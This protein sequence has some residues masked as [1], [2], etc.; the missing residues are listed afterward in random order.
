MKSYREF[1]EEMKDFPKR[2]GTG[3]V[4]QHFGMR[5]VYVDDTMDV[6]RYPR[7]N[8]YRD[9]N[10][11]REAL[12]LGAVTTTQFHHEPTGSKATVI[13]TGTRNAT[14][15]GVETPAHMRGK[16]GAH[17]VMK[18]VTDHLDRNRLNGQISVVRTDPKGANHAALKRFYAKHGFIAHDDNDV[19]MSRPHKE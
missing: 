3:L 13:Q 11:I 6:T 4:K 9:R 15:T 8:Y 1:I 14:V 2:K 17:A 10:G 12:K 16:G 19:G 18:Q 7:R 5:I